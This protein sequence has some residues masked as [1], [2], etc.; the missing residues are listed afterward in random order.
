MADRWAF[1]VAVE[2]PLDPTLGATPYA[3]TGAKA[4]ADALTLAG[5]AKANQFVLLGPHATKTAIESRLRKLKKA[6]RKR[7][8]KPEEDDE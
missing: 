8:A 3:E 6:V 4:I 7:T 5:Y 2:K 1:I